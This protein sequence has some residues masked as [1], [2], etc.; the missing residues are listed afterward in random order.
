MPSTAAAV[1]KKSTAKKVTVRPAIEMRSKQTAST[2]PSVKINAVD[3]DKSTSSRQGK[4]LRS[5][6]DAQSEEE[7]HRMISTAAYYISEKR[8]F[9]SGDE[10][11][12]WFAAE[13]A[14]A[15][16]LQGKR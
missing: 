1:S 3:A 10:L 6:R 9:N 16:M 14:I 7:R 5:P 2:K 13:E 8:G 4:T 11:A 12:D 15:A